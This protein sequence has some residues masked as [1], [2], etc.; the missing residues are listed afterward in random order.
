M[1]PIW[2]VAG[3]GAGAYAALRA[4]RVAE[5]LTPDG[6]QDRLAGLRVGWEMFSDEVRTGMAEKETELRAAVLGAPDGPA[7]LAAGTEEDGSPAVRDDARL[8][9][10]GGDPTDGHQ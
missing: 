6:L 8:D 3:V 5:A 9:A 7:R 4:R 2:F 10:S 1:R